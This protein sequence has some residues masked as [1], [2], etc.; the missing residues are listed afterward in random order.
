MNKLLPLHAG[1]LL[2]A[3]LLPC[4]LSSPVLSQ[5]NCLNFDGIGD[6]V[7]CG[8]MPQLNNTNQFTYEAWVR[9]DSWTNFAPIVGK[10]DNN[11]SQARLLLGGIQGRI[12]GLVGNGTNAQGWTQST[13]ALPL[14]TWTH[15]AMVYDGTAT[16]NANKLKL[17]INGTNQALIY[18][19]AI[20]TTTANIAGSFH[21][22][23]AA[24]STTLNIDGAVDEVRVWGK[25]LS[26]ATVNA[27]NNIPITSQHPD[28][29][30][31]LAYYMMD[32]PLTPLSLADSAGSANGVIFDALYNPNGNLNFCYPPAINATTNDASCN[33]IADGALA[34]TVTGLFSPYTYA[35][36]TGVV[37]TG[38]S[39]TG[40]SAGIYT[41]TI[42]DSWGC[43]YNSDFSIAAP[44]VINISSTITSIDCY[45]DST[46]SI[47]VTAS[48]G[49][50]PLS[51]LWANNQTIPTT[52]GWPAGTHSL[53]IT[54]SIGCTALDSFTVIQQDS[55]TISGLVTHVDCYNNTTGAIAVTAT[56]GVAPYSYLWSN[57]QTTAAVASLGAGTFTL[58]LTDD[59]GCTSQN[60]FSVNQPDSISISFSQQD[61]TCEGDDDGSA[62][63]AISGGTPA[64]STQWNVA[65]VPVGSLMVS[66]LEE[67]TVS[68]TVTDT[69]GC[70]NS[71]S[72][73]IDHL[74]DLPIVD[75]G[76]DIITPTLPAVLTPG[77]QFTSY[78]WSPGSTQSSINVTFP[79]D[80]WVECTDTNGC[81]NRDTV[82][83]FFN[84][85]INTHS[86]TG[87]VSAY[88]NPASKELTVEWS[89]FG[90]N[91][92][93]I[94]IVDLTGRVLQSKLMPYN[95]PK[96]IASIPLEEL[97]AGTYILMLSGGNQITTLPIVVE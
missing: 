25:A 15:V 85:G 95:S 46:G 42:T 96:S 81:V 61:V 22:C 89:N 41:A 10:I 69:N 66:N 39:I 56:G 52:T 84:T 50:G 18:Q 32:D 82:N 29:V 90:S 35:W 71:G 43:S 47:A 78:F 79:G 86:S 62:M 9:L 53:T 17:Y 88:P 65:G 67:G 55:F 40:L 80:Y 70:V 1:K 36:P 6:D 73:Y 14:N 28:Y 30:D 34:V 45:G 63:I 27:W 38:A 76:P 12:I 48:G 8:L 57:S 49:S 21:I 83:V 16:G 5:N 37:G 64:Y 60:A 44:P 74:F 20:P 33:N 26:A 2:L 87:L 75:L 4:F 97:N 23:E 77:P 68:V 58:S 51:Y 94:S 91:E 92:V 59:L 31:L 7:D 19:G 93:T 72:T 54:D 24:T 11:T 13:T 3:I